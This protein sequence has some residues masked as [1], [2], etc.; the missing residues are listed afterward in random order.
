MF[1]GEPGIDVHMIP[2]Q[3]TQSGEYIK[4]WNG[5]GF[6]DKHQLF[7]DGCY[8]QARQPESILQILFSAEEVPWR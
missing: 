6:T 4:R 1:V 5:H 7:S 2:R 3:T 8:W